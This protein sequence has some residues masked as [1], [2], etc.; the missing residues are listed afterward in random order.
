M[1]DVGLV[2]FFPHELG[3]LMPIL[4]LMKQEG[5]ATQD[6]QRWQLRYIVLLWLSLICM[7]PFD[8]S[9]FDDGDPK[10]STSMHLQTVGEAWLENAGL[11][12]FAAAQLLSRL[13]MRCE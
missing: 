10:A 5:Q 11:E 2:Q 7:I 13:Y 1:K 4:N 8:L 6:V 3:D 12:R 9:L